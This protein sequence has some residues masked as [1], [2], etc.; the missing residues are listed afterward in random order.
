M[1]FSYVFEESIFR[2]FVIY[3]YKREVFFCLFVCYH[4]EP[5]LLD[6]SSP[7]LA[8][9]SPLTLQRASKNFF[10]GDPPR[11]GIFLEKL[12]NQKLSLIALNEIITIFKF[13]FK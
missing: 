2:L 7:K 5:K 10:G 9:T 4:L 3:I 12:K 13:K 8:W 11:G 1:C 6:G